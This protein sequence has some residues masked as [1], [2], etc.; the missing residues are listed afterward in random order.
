MWDTAKI[1]TACNIN[2]KSVCWPCV[3][4]ATLTGK[5]SPSGVDLSDDRRIANG[6]KW[7]PFVH[8]ADHQ[9]KGGKHVLIPHL[10]AAM[11][12]GQDFRCP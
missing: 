7:C 5:K 8:E 2:R 1:A 3:I 4:M 6:A 12:R 11:L 10:T 9:G